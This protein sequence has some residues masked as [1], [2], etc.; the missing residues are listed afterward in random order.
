VACARLHPTRDAAARLRARC[1]G[2]RRQSRDGALTAG[3][4]VGTQCWASLGIA[5]PPPSWRSVYGARRRRCVRKSVDQATGRAAASRAGAGAVPQSMKWEPGP[6]R[7]HDAAVRRPHGAA[8]RRRR[9]RLA[10]IRDPG[11]RGKRAAVPDTDGALANENGSSLIMGLLRRD[12]DARSYYNS[13]G[14]WALA[15]RSSGTTSVAWCHSAS[16]FRCRSRARM[17]AAHEPAVLRFRT[18]SRQ[19]QRRC[20]PPAKPIAPTVCYEDAYGSEQLGSCGSR[21]CS[22]TSP[23]TPGSATRPRRTST[24]TSAACVRSRAAAPMLRATNDGVTALIGH[25]GQLLATAAAVPA[26]RADRRRAAA[27]W[28]HA[29]R[30]LR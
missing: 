7:A 26:R 16:S 2:L 13:V 8:P 3:A 6:A 23:T 17:D 14:A 4:L 15:S 21:R 20:L 29:V 19:I 10:R 30:A 22:S 25:D 18:G 24:S 5:S 27:H 9:H 12:A 28:S 1:S 11:A